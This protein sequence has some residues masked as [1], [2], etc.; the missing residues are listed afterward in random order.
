MLNLRR[1][2]GESFESREV[3]TIKLEKHFISCTKID[4]CSRLVKIIKQINKPKSR[5]KTRRKCRKLEPQANVFYIFRVFS[6]APR[7]L[8]QYIHDLGFFIC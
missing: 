6:N 2:S 7:V 4:L 8:S 3:Y 5:I 1:K